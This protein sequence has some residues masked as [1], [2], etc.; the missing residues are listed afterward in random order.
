MKGSGF[1]FNCVHLFYYKCH[2]INL[3]SGGSYRLPQL[4]K[5]KKT[6]PIHKNDKCFQ[7]AS[8]VIKS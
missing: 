4:D 1:E 6:N 5:N 7:Y 8:S 3:R 2:E